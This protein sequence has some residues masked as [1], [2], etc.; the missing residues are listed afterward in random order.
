MRR[1]VVRAVGACLL[2]LACV[3]GAHAQSAVDAALA[4]YARGGAYCFRVT[5]LGTALAEETEWT[6]MVLTST[7]NHR[8]T[9]RIRSVDPGET[10]LT[11]SGLMAAGRLANDVWK[12]DG[13]RADFFERFAQGIRDR[14]LRARIVKAGPPNLADI[15]SE[16]ERA[17][18]YLRFADKGTRVSFDKA[19]DLTADQFL[20][21]SEYFPD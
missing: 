4:F 18:L 10:G 21:F 1:L 15:G 12:F 17:E 19:S 8:N 2:V 13:T 6:V 9:F 7:S 11:G 3:S 16:R 14:K 20:E 5:P